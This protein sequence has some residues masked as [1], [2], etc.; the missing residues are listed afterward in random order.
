MITVDGD[1]K[2]DDEAAAVVS[3]VAMMLLV[4]VEAI[5]GAAEVVLR[6]DAVSGGEF[7]VRLLSC[8]SMFGVIVDY[9]NIRLLH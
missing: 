3:C 8:F 9:G 2:D 7:L 5:V 1:A 6:S 4:L